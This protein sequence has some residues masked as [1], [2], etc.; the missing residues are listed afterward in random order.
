[1]GQE[2][3]IE[4]SLL[5]SQAIPSVVEDT[6]EVVVEETQAKEGESVE[7]SVRKAISNLKAETGEGDSSQ[8][9]AKT[10]GNSTAK[11]EGQ[12]Q[13]NLAPKRGRPKKEVVPDLGDPYLEPPVRLRPERKEA[14]KKLPND[15][16]RDVVELFKEQES[17]FSR[18][19]GELAKAERESRHIIEAVRPYYTSIPELAQKGITESALVTTLIGTHQALMNPKTSKTKLSEI[20]QSLGHSIKFVDESG[21][22][23]V[24]TNG[25]ADIESHPQFRALQERLNQ[26][27]SYVSKQ[28][29]SEAAV[30]EISKIEEA[31]NEKDVSGNLAWPELRSKAFVDAKRSSVAE[32]RRID[33]SLSYAEA[34]KMEA[35]RHR[36]RNGNPPQLSPT[37]PR[38][39]NNNNQRAVL[40]AT[41][42]RG[43]ITPS[44]VGGATNG[45]AKPGE[46]YEDSVRAALEKI[47]RGAI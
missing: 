25:H 18:T 35:L 12:D 34:L 8:Q 19:Q 47:K 45:R 5:G 21:D 41:T 46:S 42:V 1:M 20:A 13:S 37:K 27:Q 36:V 10:G 31:Q 40:A 26:V 11:P 4:E 6:E 32:L 33:P 23:Q 44:T 7:D 43:G 28:T 39:E 29:E 15:V 38:Q 9:E 30:S 24:V 16:K 17:H 14:F 22:E 2:L 3:L